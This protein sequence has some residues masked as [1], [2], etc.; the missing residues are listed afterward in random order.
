MPFFMNECLDR[1]PVA[2]VDSGETGAP[3]NCFHDAAV[4][5]AGGTLLSCRVRMA[6]GQY[7]SCLPTGSL[8]GSK[9]E[10]AAKSAFSPVHLHTQT[11]L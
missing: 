8:C 4:Y 9:S 2:A 1:P 7:V 6:T 5:E 11:V 10:T 3:G